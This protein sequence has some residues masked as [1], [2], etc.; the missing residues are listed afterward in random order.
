MKIYT[1]RYPE[2]P[3]HDNRKLFPK[4]RRMSPQTLPQL[5]GD[6]LFIFLLGSIAIYTLN[7]RFFS[8]EPY[9]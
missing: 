9:K 8:S 7:M 1:A 5:T 4:I 6:E 2:W 3:L